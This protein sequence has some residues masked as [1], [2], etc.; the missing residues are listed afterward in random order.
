MAQA[1][2]RPETLVKVKYHGDVALPAVPKITKL[3][4]HPQDG[5]VVAICEGAPGRGFLV[6]DK[7]NFPAAFMQAVQ[8]ALQEQIKAGTVVQTNP[9]K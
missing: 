5:E 3:I 2:V 7:S 6:F 4:V 8:T 9:V 1:A